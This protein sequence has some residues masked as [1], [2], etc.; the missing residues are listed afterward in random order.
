MLEVL[1]KI[2][3]RVGLFVHIWSKS[4]AFSICKARSSSSGLTP[5]LKDCDES[6]SPF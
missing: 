5:A 4:V 2:Q 1:E 6:I 3:K